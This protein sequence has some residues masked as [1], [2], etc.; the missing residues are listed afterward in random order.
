MLADT[1]VP[2][3][4][5]PPAAQ[6]ARTGSTPA[7]VWRWPSRTLCTRH[8]QLADLVQPLV[9]SIRTE[10]HAEPY[11]CVDATGVLVLAQ[12]ALPGWPF[13]G[14]GRAGEGTSSSSTP[15][16]ARQ[17]CRRHLAGRV[18]R[19]PGRRRSRRLRPPVPQRG[20]DRSRVLGHTPRRY[21]F[22]T[23]ASDPERAKTALA[24]IAALFS[25]ERSLVSTPSKK[26]REIRQARAAP[27]VDDFFAWCDV[28]A[29]RILDESP[30][31]T[32]LAT[33]GSQTV[34]LRRFLHDGPACPCTTTLRG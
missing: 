19:L 8:E 23:L 15:G 31:R 28:E 2:A 13:L 5:G 4:A 25:L 1:I 33:R 7:R 21:F 22:N 3:I 10:A 20:R 17:R 34:A 32:A 11:L 14:R 30:S 29:D 9:D 12:G 16:P 18:H 26:R 6:P 27:I 24:W